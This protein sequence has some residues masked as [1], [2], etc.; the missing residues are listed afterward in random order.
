MISEFLPNI[1]LTNKHAEDTE[2][3]KKQNF[4]RC[5]LG[6][7]VCNPSIKTTVKGGGNSSRTISKPKLVVGKWARQWGGGGLPAPG[8][9]WSIDREGGPLQPRQQIDTPTQLRHEP[10]LSFSV[11]FCLLHTILSLLYLIQSTLPFIHFL[12]VWIYVL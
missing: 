3:R 12:C 2:R 7:A 6:K 5:L 1:P 4:R 10:S 8:R 9:V 11:Y